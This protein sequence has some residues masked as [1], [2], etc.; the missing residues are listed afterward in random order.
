MRRKWI[1]L[2][3]VICGTKVLICLTNKLSAETFKFFVRRK[4]LELPSSPLLKTYFDLVGG[5]ILQFIRKKR[6]HE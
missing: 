4:K 6:Q 3:S 5:K 2:Q 1:R